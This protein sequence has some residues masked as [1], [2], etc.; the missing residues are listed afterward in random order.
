[1]KMKSKKTIINFVQ[2]GEHYDDDLIDKVHEL[3]EERRELEWQ[4]R[5]YTLSRRDLESEKKSADSTRRN[6]IENRLNEL[7]KKCLN[8]KLNPINQ[9]SFAVI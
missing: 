5:A 8:V 9:T 4:K 3:S 7:D 1:M 2:H 6:K